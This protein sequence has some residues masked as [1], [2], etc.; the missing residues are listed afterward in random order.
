MVLG[1]FWIFGVFSVFLHPGT[2]ILGNRGLNRKLQVDTYILGVVST[3]NPSRC[4]SKIGLPFTTINNLTEVR[5]LSQIRADFPSKPLP[6]CRY[7]LGVSDFGPDFPK[8]W[9]PYKKTKNFRPNPK[10]TFFRAPPRLQPRPGGGATQT[11]KC[12]AR[13]AS[14]M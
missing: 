12:E 9:F 8:Y 5:F 1:F 4:D 13:S 14:Q 3:E 2:N 11:L 6:V 7:R 10:R